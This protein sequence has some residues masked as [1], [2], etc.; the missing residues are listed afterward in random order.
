MQAPRGD[1]PHAGR[2]VGHWRGRAISQRA[3]A[4]LPFK[5]APPATHSA[6]VEQH[7]A[8]ICAQ[9]KLFDAEVLAR[10]ARFSRVANMGAARAAARPRFRR[11]NAAPATLVEISVFTDN[12]GLVGRTNVSSALAARLVGLTCQNSAATTCVDDASIRRIDGWMRCIGGS[13]GI[14]RT[15]PCAT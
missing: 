9:G 11:K 10:N 7:A 3:I 14:D 12:G 4:E 13:A 2:D 5:I 15:S 6:C 8:V 1:G